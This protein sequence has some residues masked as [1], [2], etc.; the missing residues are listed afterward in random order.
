MIFCFFFVPKF[1]VLFKRYF[2]LHYNGTGNPSIQ[3][4]LHFYESK[5][6]NDLKV[7]SMTAKHIMHMTQFVTIKKHLKDAKRH[8]NVNQFS[9]FL[10]INI[11]NVSYL[12]LHSINKCRL[13][14]FTAALHC[15]KIV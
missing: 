15:S 1:S 8:K 2:L 14:H 5:H 12:E 6:N 4:P 9:N 13:R 11:P 10:F 3:L 7:M